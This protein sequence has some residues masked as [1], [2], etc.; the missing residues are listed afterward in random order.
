MKKKSI[1]LFFIIIFSLTNIMYLY[2][3]DNN[4]NIGSVGDS[5]DAIWYNSSMD[6]Q[7]S[8]YTDISWARI[9]LFNGDTKEKLDTFIVSNYF[10]EDYKEVRLMS[11]EMTKIDYINLNGNLTN[12]LKGY[13]V[14]ED[15]YITLS[16]VKVDS[17]FPK[18]LIPKFKEERAVGNIREYF[19]DSEK[20][21]FLLSSFR[22]IDDNNINNLVL[23]IE[24][25]SLF[26]YNI[27]DEAILPEDFV[28]SYILLT[29]AEV[30]LLSYNNHFILDSKIGS[31]RGITPF[32]DYYY[33][34][35][36]NMLPF[37]C[38]K[39]D[40]NKL[41]NILPCDNKYKN[42]WTITD[43]NGY[44]DMI[45]SLGCFEVYWNIA[46]VSEINKA[47]ESQILF[48][49]HSNLDQ[50]GG[51]GSIEE[52]YNLIGTI[53][54]AGCGKRFI[55]IAL[56]MVYNYI[57]KVK[58][59]I[60]KIESEGWYIVRQKGSHRQYKNNNI[61]GLVTIAG[62][63]SDEIDKGTLNSILKQAGLK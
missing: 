5:E 11:P 48:K 3:E 31:E 4:T 36:Y 43:S 51:S 41:D 7:D 26:K 9:S 62:K 15:E 61:K 25:M 50:I 34:T 49:F 54:K 37:S 44:L 30:G 17:N 10:D 33:T 35:M 1:L 60:K 28:Y 8:Q 18:L 27:N 55:D 22:D 20:V 39:I 24:P 53:G 19:N 14:I 21:K 52:E 46:T 16:D 38:F 23:L 45:K 6:D 57:M 12:E 29:C 13:L 2:A 58:E 40:I 32:K 56:V 63:L 59:I 42:S 47:T